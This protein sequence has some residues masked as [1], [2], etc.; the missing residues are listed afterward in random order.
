[1]IQL[2]TQASEISPLVTAGDDL[3]SQL[4]VLRVR[5]VGRP[6]AKSAGSDSDEHS[7]SSR[8]LPVQAKMLRDIL[9]R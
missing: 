6:Q 8:A 2:F 1:M 4:A 7:S 9:N 3:F 5:T